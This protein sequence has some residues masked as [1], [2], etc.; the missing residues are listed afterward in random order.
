MALFIQSCDLCLAFDFTLLGHHHNSMVLDRQDSPFSN[1]SPQALTYSLVQQPLSISLNHCQHR[2]PMSL[3]HQSIKVSKSCHF[4]KL[5]TISDTF[6]H[7]DLFVLPLQHRHRNCY[8]KSTLSP[9]YRNELA[10]TI[11]V[12]IN[13]RV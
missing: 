2:N 13:T 3:Y 12:M 10:K 7:K 8:R 9:I 6:V 5:R 1:K 4:S 11:V